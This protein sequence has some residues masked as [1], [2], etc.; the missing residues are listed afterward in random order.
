MEPRTPEMRRLAVL[1]TGSVSV[2]DLPYWL[3]WLGRLHP[4]IEVRAGLTR[5]ATRFVTR[6]ALGARTGRDAYLDDWSDAAGA[7]HVEL[8]EWAEAIIV[9]PATLDFVGRL[10]NGAANSPFLL[11]AQCTA[12]PVGVAPALPPGAADGHVYR[13]H[14]EALRARENVVVLPPVPAMSITTGRK[15]A[16]APGPLPELL[17]QVEDRRRALADAASGTRA[18]GGQE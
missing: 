10:A 14:L 6:E 11:A 18:R 13:M 17:A 4:G 7:R 3:T 8:A 2:T 9:Y 16:W 5:S 15:D 1:G 12:G